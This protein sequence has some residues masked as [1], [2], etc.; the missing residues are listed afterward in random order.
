MA[1]S[2]MRGHETDALRLIMAHLSPPALRKCRGVSRTWGNAADV[3]CLW[4]SH[5][6]AHCKMQ[7]QGRA[8]SMDVHLSSM[9]T[10]MILGTAARE[11]KTMAV[12]VS[13]Q[14]HVS[15]QI[16]ELSRAI[17]SYLELSFVF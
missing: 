3:G 7:Y 4:L 8:T 9:Q 5:Q 6:L 10:G 1:E 14:I 17:S 13:S 11:D 16:G 12:K 15:E 2:A